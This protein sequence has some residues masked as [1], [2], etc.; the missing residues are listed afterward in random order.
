[1]VGSKIMISLILKF[2]LFFLP[3]YL[4][5]TRT[6]T[7][8]GN[9]QCDH[10]SVLTHG[11]GVLYFDKYT[12]HPPAPHVLSLIMFSTD[13]LS[14]HGPPVINLIY[15]FP[16][17]YFPLSHQRNTK[18]PCKKKTESCSSEIRSFKSVYNEFRGDV[19]EL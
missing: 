7:L 3:L 5:N 1:M 14:I 8:S 11:F 19:L 9:L 2:Q 12:P 13:P 18:Y 16:W 10:I 6:V 17:C 4:T 15:S